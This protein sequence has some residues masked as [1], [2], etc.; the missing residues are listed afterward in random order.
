MAGPRRVWF[1]LVLVCGAAGATAAALQHTTRGSVKQRRAP[2]GLPWRAGAGAGDTVWLVRRCFALPLLYAERARHWPGGMMG[3]PKPRAAVRASQPACQP[4]GRGAGGGW[5]PGAASRRCDGAGCRWLHG[6]H[7]ATAQLLH[8]GR[9]ANT[10]AA[11]RRLTSMARRRRERAVHAVGARMAVNRLFAHMHGLTLFLKNPCSLVQR[12][13]AHMHLLWV[14]RARW[15]S[16][17]SPLAIGKILDSKADPILLGPQKAPPIRIVLEN[18]SR[19]SPRSR[20][21]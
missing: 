10:H 3:G 6:R 15:F 9:F 4:R 20:T 13:V 16:H 1:G 12:V 18:A 7:A 19:R 8:G 11:G 2:G 17:R 5:G 21:R 14:K